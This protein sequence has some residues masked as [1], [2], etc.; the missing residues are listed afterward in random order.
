ML[1][2][3]NL[4]GSKCYEKDLKDLIVI[5]NLSGTEKNLKPICY[6]RA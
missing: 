4:K 1:Q 6:N 5:V 3:N 2:L